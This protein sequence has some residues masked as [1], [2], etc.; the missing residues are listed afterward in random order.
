MKVAKVTSRREVKVRVAKNA[1]LARFL[2]GPVGRILIASVALLA[3][4]GIGVFTFLYV[5]YSRLIDEKLKAGPFAATAKIYAAPEAVSVGDVRTAESIAAALRRSG[6]NESHSNP[7]R[8]GWFE[9]RGNSIEIYPG[10]DSYFDQEPGVIKFSG[11]RISQIIS[12]GDNTS[13]PQYELEPELITNL[14]GPSREKR[15]FVKFADIPKILVEAVTSAEDKRFFQH[16]GLD[17]VR[18]IKAAYVDLKEGK[19]E[20]G[21]STLSQQLARM[22][23]LDQDKKWTRKLA[24]VV[25]TLQIEQKLSKEEIFED[26]ANQVPMGMRGTF[27]IHGFGE[28]SEAYLGKEDDVA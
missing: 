24:E 23:W 9:M 2:L 27:S 17:P 15:R 11:G 4:V 16:N 18:I 22:F 5:K 6:Y 12:L 19:K 28:A 21:A 10:P 7:N 8:I 1:A 20:Q 3:V 26:Y 13:R 25:I 14:S